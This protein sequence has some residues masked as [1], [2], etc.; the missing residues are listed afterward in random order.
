MKLEVTLKILINT[1][2]DK[3]R[4]ARQVESLFEFG[5]IG[6]SFVD[7]LKLNETP[8]LS[9]ISVEPAPTDRSR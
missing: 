5:A 1:R 7:A 3:K 2:F 9:G 6:E 4:V 8:R